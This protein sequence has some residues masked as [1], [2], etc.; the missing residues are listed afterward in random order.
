MKSKLPS[1]SDL[2]EGVSRRGETN[3]G[4]KTEGRVSGPIGREPGPC[5]AAGIWLRDSDSSTTPIFVFSIHFFH[6]MNFLRG[7]AQRE[8]NVSK[9]VGSG[10]GEDTLLFYCCMCESAGAAIMKYRD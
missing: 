2:S 5:S 8:E 7:R 10:Q 1:Q 4:F 9:A 3:M 6:Q